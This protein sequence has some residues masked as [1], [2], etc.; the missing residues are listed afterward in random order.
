MIINWNVYGVVESLGNMANTSATN[1]KYTRQ[2]SI[3][4]Y[5][6]PGQGADQYAQ[7]YVY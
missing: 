5:W 7:V 4:Q 3:Y 1:I 6:R 2:I